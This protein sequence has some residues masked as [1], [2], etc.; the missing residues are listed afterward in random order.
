MPKHNKVPLSAV[1][2]LTL[3]QGAKTTARRTK[4]VRASHRRQS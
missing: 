3:R 4:A 1:R 2:T